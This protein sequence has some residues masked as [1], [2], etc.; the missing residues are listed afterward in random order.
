VA[1]FMAGFDYWNW[2]TIA[3]VLLV[4]ELVAP[5]VFFLWIGLAAMVV[6]FVA[7]LFPD[8]GWQIDFALFAVLSVVAA[9]IGRRFWK[10]K[11]GDSPDPTLNQRGQQYVGQILTLQA[12]IEN[13]HGRANAGDSSWAVIGPD[14]PIGAR[15]RVVGVEGA[16]LKVEDA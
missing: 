2:W 1:E 8:I 13:G 3:I 6:G 12:A 11:A 16:K 9:L 5:G 4:I 14:L 10:A 7:F 15:V